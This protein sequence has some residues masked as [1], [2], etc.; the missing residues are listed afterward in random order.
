MTSNNP[1]PQEIKLARK[2]AGLSQSQAAALLYLDKTTL[3]K[4]EYGVN[5]M[6]LDRW[7][8]LKLKIL[9]LDLVV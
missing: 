4:W 1:N 5:P 9:G 7:E 2:R 6:P 3:Q 8:D